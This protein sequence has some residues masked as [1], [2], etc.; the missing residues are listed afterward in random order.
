[1]RSPSRAVCLYVGRPQDAPAITAAVEH[2]AR[3]WQPDVTWLISREREY[4]NDALSVEELALWF[5]AGLLDLAGAGLLLLLARRWLDLPAGPTYWGTAFVLGLLGPGPISALCD[6]LIFTWP[7]AVYV[8]FHATVLAYVWAGREPQRRRCWLAR[9]TL[10]A[11]LLIGWGYFELCRAAGMYIVW[12][13]LAGFPAALPLTLLAV[14]AE[15][16][17]QRPW[18]IALWTLPAFALFFA[19]GQALLWCKTT[20]ETDFTVL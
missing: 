10:A 2:P 9:L 6:R 19:S 17:G 14:R 12:A 11:M 5:G 4:P 15:I 1:V 20:A 16:N 7:L 3:S 13:F 18:L 8:A